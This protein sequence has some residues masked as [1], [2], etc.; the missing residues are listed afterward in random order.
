MLGHF[1]VVRGQW[2]RPRSLW[3]LSGS[4]WWKGSF[5]ITILSTGLPSKKYSVKLGT[6]I[7]K[8][9]ILIGWFQKRRLVICLE[10]SPVSWGTFYLGTLY[11]STLGKGSKKKKK[12]MWNFPHLGIP[13]LR[14]NVEIYSF[15]FTI[16]LDVL[17]YFKHIREKK[18]FFPLKSWKHLEFSHKFGLFRRPNPPIP[19]P[20][21]R[22]K[23]SLH[24][25]T[26]QT[27]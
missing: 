9:M 3:C 8:W 13:P 23:F 21:P 15:F 26:F 20:S 11:H 12:K 25:W 6:I 14:Q 22:E 4:R 1:Q 5:E 27:I 7:F 18:I 17:A 19:P 10:S 24:F 2:N 16:F